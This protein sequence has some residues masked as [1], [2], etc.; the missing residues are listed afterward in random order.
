MQLLQTAQLNFR[1]QK[2]NKLI[3]FR[4]RGSRIS[5]EEQG[6]KSM[7]FQPFYHYFC[8]GNK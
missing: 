3:P 5:N 6:G 1:L 8:V 4:V 2:I 7:S